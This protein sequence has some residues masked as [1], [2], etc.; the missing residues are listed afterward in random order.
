[1]TK[2]TKLYIT[3]TTIEDIYEQDEEH[4][5]CIDGQ[6]YLGKV[7]YPTN[8]YGIL[9]YRIH[10]NIFYNFPYEDVCEFAQSYDS[11]EYLSENIEIVQVIMRE[12]IWTVVIKTFWLKMLQWRWRRLCNQ[13]KEWLL[14]VKKNI[15]GLTGM[16]KRLPAWP[17]L[18]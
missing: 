6:Y 4:G 2:N 10:T 13:R 9:D 18:Q 16:R 3:M 17:T 14:N 15:V 7:F 5:E 1:M 8:E 11:E 12:D